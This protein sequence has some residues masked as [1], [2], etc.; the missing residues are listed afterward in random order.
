MRAV[1]I[2]RPGGPEVLE[3]REVADPTPTK[4]ELLVRVAAS[5]LNRADLLQRRGMYPAPPG[6]P[7]DIPG[8]ELAGTVVACGEG[9]TRFAPGDE[10]MAVV[11]GGACAELAVVHEREAIRRPLGM[12]ASV[13][14]AIPEAF[15]T[16]FDAIVLQGGLASG[17]WLA[18][19]AVASGVGT[20]AIQI[21]RAIGARSVGS[22]RTEAKLERALSLGLDVGVHGV[23]AD[24]AKKAREVTG[25]AGVAVGL[26][27]VGGPALSDM[28]AALRPRGTAIL[29]GLMAGAKAELNL[30]TVLQKRLH[31][32]G[33][34][35]RSRP[36]EEKMA[37]ARAFEDRIQPLF[38]GE[39]PLL[40]PVVDQVFPMEAVAEAHIALEKNSAFGKIVLFHG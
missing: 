8:L 39:A 18:V 33:T 21:A 1:V 19:D 15:M 27:L 25:G 34:V 38:E 5:A 7:K 30:V 4:G 35:L 32:V 12:P 14:A 3:L 24:L 28:I 9:V 22:T 6:S 23:T 16:A 29:V 17:Q 40:R 10:V 11:G 31:V 13:A 26:S 2:T 20:A 36:A 37:V